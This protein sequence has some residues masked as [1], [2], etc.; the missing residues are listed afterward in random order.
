[1][2]SSTPHNWIVYNI[3][4]LSLLGYDASDS[5][6]QIN[7]QNGLYSLVWQVKTDKNPLVA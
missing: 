3:T 1:M 2:T 5:P 6:Q 7:H 4:V